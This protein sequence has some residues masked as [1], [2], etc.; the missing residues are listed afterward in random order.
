MAS[1]LA[2]G[3]L[4]TVA[5]EAQTA[6]W[7][8]RPGYSNRSRTAWSPRTAARTSTVEQAEDEE[9]QTSS[10]PVRRMNGS[11]AAVSSE[12]V[13]SAVPDASEFAAEPA[14]PGYRT[15]YVSGRPGC[16]PAGCGPAV[17]SDCGPSC[18]PGPSGGWYD[19]EC[20]PYANGCEYTGD[21]LGLRWLGYAMHDRVWVRADYLMWWTRSNGY[22]ALLTT[23]PADSAQNQAGVLGNPDTEIL[24]GEVGLNQNLRNGGR[25]NFGTWFDRANTVGIDFTYL[26]L[27]RQAEEI[28][29][30]SDGSQILARP[31]F[32]VETGLQ[33]SHLLSFPDLVT[34]GATISSATELQGGEVLLRRALCRAPNYRVDMMVGYRFQRLKEKLRIAEAVVDVDGNSLT[35]LDEFGTIND[36]HGGEL[37]V[38]IQRR[39]CRW[40]LDSTMKLAIGNT[41]TR[42]TIDGQTVT[43]PADAAPGDPQAGGFLALPTNIGVHEGNRLAVIPELAVNLGYNL[44]PR[45][46]AIVG[47][48]FVYWSSVTRPGNLVDLDI[49]PSQFPPEVS[50][51]ATRPAYAQRTTDFWAQGINL[52]LDFRF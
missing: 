27:A 13:E 50:T 48:T 22:P 44:T 47:Y 11:R 10:P 23:G 12:V 31:F 35:A 32:N 14:G 19:D 1:F 9:V 42:A 17:G 29:R 34:G 39:F 20:F 41:H 51:T 38:A 45:L 8:Q 21:P 28:Q 5:A 43:T 18:G 30:T 6:P 4:W 36:F 49:N 2:I 24:V 26:G 7:Q 25:L 46:R 37:G 15:P 52:G 3:G 40:T 33:D 16:S